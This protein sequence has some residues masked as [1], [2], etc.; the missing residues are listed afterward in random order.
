MKQLESHDVTMYDYLVELY[1]QRKSQFN[2]LEREILR[3]AYF[4]N[5]AEMGD[6][7]WAKA[8]TRLDHSHHAVCQFRLET[9]RINAQK[10][11]EKESIE[12]ARQARIRALDDA[13]MVDLREELTNGIVLGGF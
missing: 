6:P 3:G 9:D 4:M 7:R 2:Q 10:R 1:N 11:A 5:A 13:E 12:Q 8:R